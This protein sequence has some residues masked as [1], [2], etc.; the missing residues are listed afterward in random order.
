M[1][2]SRS[3]FFTSLAL[4]FLAFAVTLPA[5]A[6][7]KSQKAKE[8]QALQNAQPDS[9]Q[10]QKSSVLKTQRDQVN[11]AIGANF[12][13]AIKQQGIDIDLEMVMRGIKDAHAGKDLLMTDEEIRK[14][15]IVYHGE[16]QRKQAKARAEAAENRRRESEAFLMENKNK[17]GIVVLPSGVQYRVIKEGHGNKPTDSDVVE[18]HYRSTLINGAEFDSSFR[19]GHS[20]IVK[21]ADLVPGWREALKLMPVGSK[22]QVFIPSQLAYGARGVKGSVGPNETLIIEME[23]LAVK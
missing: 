16:V 1:L 15:I 7:A 5:D 14:A 3:I 2:Q 13:G 17:E 6:H 10:A 9:N 12:M 11:Y 22:W 8:Q 18:L 21:V 4:I 23:L 20:A 19:T